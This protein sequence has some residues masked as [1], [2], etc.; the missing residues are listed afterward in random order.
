MNIELKNVT[1]SKALSQET[2][3]YTADIWVD[4]KKRGTVR[5]QGQGG[6]DDIY[7]RELARDL[8]VHA[9]TLPPTDCYGTMLKPSVEMVLGELLE[10]YLAAKELK[11]IFKKK[12][13]FIAADGKLYSVLGLK[14]PKDAVRV[15]NMIPF[16]QAL[17]AYIAG[18]AP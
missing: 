2:S 18:T 12:C 13:L 6:C 9:A 1:Y 15:L 17:E 7:P 3:A 4:G 5:N 14:P 11:R 16:D 10:K 8:A